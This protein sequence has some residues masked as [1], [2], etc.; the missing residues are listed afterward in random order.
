MLF[1]VLTLA[2]GSSVEIG[3][4]QISKV[5]RAMTKNKCSFSIDVFPR[6]PCSANNKI[7]V[8]NKKWF[9][10]IVWI[11]IMRLINLLLVAHKLCAASTVK[12]IDNG[13]GDTLNGLEEKI[14]DYAL[15]AADEKANLP[16]QV[17][18]GF[19]CAFTYMYVFPVH[20]MLLYCYGSF[21]QHNLSFPTSPRV[22]GS[23]DQPLP[24][25]KQPA[26]QAIGKQ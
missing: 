14:V 19:V 18:L 22:W 24:W 21:H 15:L 4:S 16:S 6:A 5:I 17:C 26:I 3:K 13:L 23:L 11:D 20:Y 12:V 1:D 9:A 10:E 25:W 8:E 2:W 7:N